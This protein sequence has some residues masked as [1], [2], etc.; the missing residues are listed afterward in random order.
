MEPSLHDLLRVWRRTR[1]RSVADAIDCLSDQLALESPARPASDWLALDASPAAL[2]TLLAAVPPVAHPL[3]PRCLDAFWRWPVDPR[4][5]TALQRLVLQQLPRSN[6]WM[7][8][9]RALALIA[10]VGDVRAADW[11]AAAILEVDGPAL[12]TRWLVQRAN[13]LIVVLGQP[14]RD[15]ERSSVRGRVRPFGPAPADLQARQVFADEL[16]EQGDLRGE[17]IAL[18]SLEAPRLDQLRRASQLIRDYGRPWLGRLSGALKP[19]GLRFERGVV[20]AGKVSGYRALRTVLGAP[21]WSTVEELD[22]SELHRRR[23][24]GSNLMS[25]LTQESLRNLKRVR[26]FPATELAELRACRVPTAIEEL[27]LVGWVPAVML[28]GLAARPALPSLRKVTLNG[29]EVVIR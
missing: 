13:E 14:A 2:P 24:A 27:H 6:D 29:A 9:N 26:A 5:T 10:W 28:D 25:F 4:L 3:L 21:E 11:L 23:P 12:H 22:L 17:L 19:Q 8:W 7:F 16:Q 20:V 18:Q 1:C 15:V